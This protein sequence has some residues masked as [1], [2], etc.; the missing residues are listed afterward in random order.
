MTEITLYN[1][2]KQRVGGIVKKLKLARLIHKETGRPLSLAITDILTLGL[3]KQFGQIATKKKLYEIMN[4][5]CSYK[6]LVVLL[7]RFAYLALMILHLLMKMNKKIQHLVKHIDSTALPVCLNKNTKYHKTMKDY[8]QWGNSGHGWFYGLKLHIITDLLDR[9]LSMG[10]TT[11]N[12]DDRK[13]VI[14]LSKEIFGFL[15]GDAGYVSKELMKQFYQTSKRVFIVKPYKNMKKLASE[16]DTWLYD[17]RWQIEFNFR[18]LKMFFG[19]VTSLPRSVKG[20][21]ANYIYSILAYTLTKAIPSRSLS[22]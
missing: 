1:Q 17:T 10:L 16:L 14:P 22:N 9:L 4:L 2:L 6:T 5:N 19:L 21:L 3:F 7:N 11:G 18:N 20:Y 8:A 12:T 15:I 13:M